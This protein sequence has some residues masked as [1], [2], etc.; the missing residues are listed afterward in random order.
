MIATVLLQYAG[1][2]VLLFCYFAESQPVAAAAVL[3]C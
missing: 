1:T 2:L 3:V